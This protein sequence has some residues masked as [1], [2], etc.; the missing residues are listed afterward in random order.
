MTTTG[1]E[2]FFKRAKN[3]LRF[4]G[5]TETPGVLLSDVF[6]YFF[7]SRRVPQSLALASEIRDLSFTL[8][9]IEIGYWHFQLG[10][11]EQFETNIKPVNSIHLS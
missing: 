9:H 1:K 5:I 4:V 2:I 10:N 8:K 11:D 7:I 6:L 3:T